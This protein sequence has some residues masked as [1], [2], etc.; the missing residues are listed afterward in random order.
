VGREGVGREGGR[1]GVGGRGRER[2]EEGREGGREE[3]REAG[4]A[5][6][7]DKELAIPTPLSHTIVRLPK[8]VWGI[9][10]GF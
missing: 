2:G 7:T 6:G 5:E 3:G 4:E 9:Q 1:E 10:Y 8:Q